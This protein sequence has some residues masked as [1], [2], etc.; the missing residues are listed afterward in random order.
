MFAID[1]TPSAQE[2]Y[3]NIFL[4]AS[5]EPLPE[6]ASLGNDAVFSVMQR[7]EIPPDD[8]L[9][10]PVLTDDYNPLDTQQL[11]FLV[12]FREDMIRK[13]QS[14]LLFDGTR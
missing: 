5:H 12:L 8:G 1:T 6:P 7:G 2:R 14:V 13:G 10:V 3:T 4:A 11:S 9:A